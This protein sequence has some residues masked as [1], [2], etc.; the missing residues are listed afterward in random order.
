MP[1][2]AS[3][4]KNDQAVRVTIVLPH[5]AGKIKR[6]AAFVPSGKEKAMDAGADIAGNELIENRSTGKADFDVAVAT[7]DMMP[8]R[9]LIR[10]LVKVSCR[11]KTGSQCKHQK[12]VEELKK[13]KSR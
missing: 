2:L 4:L 13:V 3:T 5:A 7:P 1:T 6:I 10:F 8:N 11:I 9:Q 12:M